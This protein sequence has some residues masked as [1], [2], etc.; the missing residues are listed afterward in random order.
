MDKK[1]YIEF[2]NGD[3]KTSLKQVGKSKTSGT[4]NYILFHRKIYFHQ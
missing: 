1:Y 2:K 3:A 4:R